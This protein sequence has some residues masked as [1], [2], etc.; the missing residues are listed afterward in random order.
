MA[1]RVIEGSDGAADAVLRVAV[2]LQAGVTPVRAWRYLA[3]GGDAV[4]SA[5]CRRVDEGA[6]FPAAM[7]ALGG[8]WTEV[9]A[10]WSVSA[11]VGAP[12]AD[13][14]RSFAAA[15]RDARET[16]DQVRVALAEPAGTARLMAWLPLVGVAL[17]GA[18]GLDTLGIL[19]TQPAGIACLVGGVALVVIA[20]RWTARLVRRAQPERGASGVEAELLAIA[21][22]GGVSL[23]R[24]REVVAS[25]GVTIDDPETVRVLALSRA[26]GVPAVELLRAAA[27]LARHAARVDGR[28]RAARLSSKLLLPLG[29]CTLPAFLLLGVAPTILGV[30]SSMSLSL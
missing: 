22:S 26:A 21:V 4:A 18:L 14:L 27:A 13:T 23:D 30:L 29:V 8:S 5:V 19:V 25:T 20:Q 3:D 9:A 11:S 17:G 6:P 1:R 15:L 24:A 7:R 28:L 12:L 10:A 16:A 2:L